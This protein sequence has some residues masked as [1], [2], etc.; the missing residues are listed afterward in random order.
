MPVVSRLLRATRLGRMPLI[1]AVRDG[2][3]IYGGLPL[4]GALAGLPSEAEFAPVGKTHLVVLPGEAACRA[5]PAE[6]EL[7]DGKATLVAFRNGERAEAAADWLAYHRAQHG[8]EAAL[9][10]DRAPPGSDFAEA[11]DALAPEL[12]VTV[13]QAD[14][15][16]GVPGA[17]DMRHP[18]FAPAAPDRT[19]PPQDPWHGP[20][21]QAVVV[22]LLWRRFLDR[23][24]A[25][26]FLDLPDLL[27]PATPG[28]FER[29][30]DAPDGLLTARGIEAYPWRL[31]RGAP[32][33]HSDHIATRRGEPRGIFSW[34]CVP[35]KRPEG[36]LRVPGRQELAGIATSAP[37]PYV[38]AIGV[39]FPGTPVK[40]LVRK[41]DLV[42]QPHL[43]AAMT[44]GFGA[45]PIRL[46]APETI[47]P[48][49]AQPR[50]TL[51]SAM[52]N[53]GPF[54]LDWIA[55]NRVLGVDHHLVYT[56]DCADGTEALLDALAP[57]GVTRRDNPFREMGKVPQFAAFKAAEKEPVVREADWLLTLDVD[58][59][60]NIHVG[61]GRLADLMAAVPE[62]H[63][64]SM[65]WR[66]FGNAD[67]AHFEDRPVTERFT[68]AAPAFAP[69]PLQAWAFKTLYRNAGLFRRL[70]VH[71]PKGLVGG[72]QGQIHWVDGGGRLIPPATWR[73][74]WRMSKAAWSYQLVTVNHYAVRSAESFLIK[75]DRGRVNHVDRD[76]GATYWFRMNHNAEE[77]RT[78]AR[79]APQV[80]EEKARLLALPG[81]AEA[82]DAAVGWHRAKI[83]ELRAREDHAALFAQI[84]GD[85]LKKLSRLSTF[86]G[87]WEHYHGPDTIPDEVA[88]RDP[89]QPFFFTS[90]PSA[91]AHPHD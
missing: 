74:C 61:A 39:M 4:G 76:Q 5:D 14:T 37:I 1:A 32:A 64:V 33:P 65:P 30:R 26:L 56:N 36:L 45:S 9:I 52:K 24:G 35:G 54:I 63:V 40:A 86:F 59:Y 68:L 22:E 43:L 46:P 67:L 72:K 31:R 13:V 87:A 47:A 7:F 21:A 48:R 17:F 79:Y 62:A 16:L 41:G 85:K 25:V 29:L 12:P 44:D 75:R 58:E 57:A 11:L 34:G 23:A 60:I 83:A 53:E 42:E 81:V 73:G 82:H 71:R 69:R 50:I 90:N 70:G 27:L 91:R 38:R 51:V 78:I 28:A 49:P 8:A 89:S 20:M 15:P 19:R 18:G 55:H 80:A 10:F 6:T 2:D 66:L 77:E 3:R 84:T 88:E